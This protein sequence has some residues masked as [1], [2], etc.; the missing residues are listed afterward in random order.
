VT[1]TGSSPGRLGDR[2]TRD[3]RTVAD[4]EGGAIRDERGLAGLWTVWATTVV[5]AVAVGALGRGAALVARHRAETAA[6]LTALAAATAQV[7][8]GDPCG[9][10]GRVASAQG[11][12]LVSCALQA[13]SV[14]VLVEVATPSRVLRWLD[15][16]PA[17]ARARAG[18]PP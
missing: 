17:R 10:A 7:R 12:R 4:G 18:V 3:G 14:S 11:A 9:V 5:L 2:P 13:R 6:D 15:M 8:G 1:G 16:P